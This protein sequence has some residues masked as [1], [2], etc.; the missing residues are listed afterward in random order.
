MPPLP[1]P[2]NLLFQLAVG[3]QTSNLISESVEGLV[4]AATLQ[5]PG[6]SFAETKVRP[7]RGPG[8][9]KEEGG[10]NAPAVTVC[11]NLIAVSGS[12]RA[13]RLS[14]V[15]ATLLS[16]LNIFM[17]IAAQ[18]TIRSFIGHPCGAFGSTKLIRSC[19]ISWGRSNLGSLLERFHV[20]LV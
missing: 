9:G 13:V 12:L 15:A 2:I 20:P 17:K 4:T 18:I 3:I 16:E 11:A 10:L 7:P 1:T 8:A 14:H 5:N 19:A 6:S